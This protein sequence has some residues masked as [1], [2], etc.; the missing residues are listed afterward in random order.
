LAFPGQVVSLVPGL[1][2]A[3]QALASPGEALSQYA[4]D[5]KSEGLK[6]REAIR[7]Q[8]LSEAEKEGVLSSFATAITSTLK[9]PALISTF[10][11]EQLPLLLPPLAAARVTQMAGRGAVSQ[12]GQGLSGDAARLAAE[13]AA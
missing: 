10:L 4:Q 13:E 12:A 8:A 5:L 1:R 6:A 2:E 3:G 9:D 7:S 11:A